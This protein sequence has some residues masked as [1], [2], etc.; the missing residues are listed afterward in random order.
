MM[1]YRLSRLAESDLANILEASERR[2]GAEGRRRYSAILAA[3]T[4]KVATDPQGPATRD[5]TELATGIRSFPIRHARADDPKAKVRRP[6]HILYCRTVAPNLIEIVRVL[7]E[8]ME[9][10]RHFGPRTKGKD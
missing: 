5:R 2:W 3:A 1:R 6:V 8:R 9:P 10:S 4:R 7:H